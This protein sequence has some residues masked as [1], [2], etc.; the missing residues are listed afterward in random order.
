MCC[1]HGIHD[2]SLTWRVCGTSASPWWVYRPTDLK[3]LSGLIWN[4]HSHLHDAMRYSFPFQGWIIVSSFEK[5]CRTGGLKPTINIFKICYQLVTNTD[6]GNCC[7]CNVG[8]VDELFMPP[9]EVLL[10]GRK[11]VL[12]L[13]IK[14]SLRFKSRHPVLWLL[15]IYGLQEFG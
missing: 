11:K 7:W 8:G 2:L 1:G 6:G 3:H 14:L 4:Y 13:I 10:L 5:F 15:G 9:E 12:S